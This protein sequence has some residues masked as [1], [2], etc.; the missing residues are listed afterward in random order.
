MNDLLALGGNNNRYL[1]LYISTDWCFYQ[2]RGHGA[3]YVKESILG[4]R[5]GRV[6][7]LIY[8]V[9]YPHAE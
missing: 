8:V 5:I 6:L 4:T 1:K 2:T 7:Y 9:F 3:V